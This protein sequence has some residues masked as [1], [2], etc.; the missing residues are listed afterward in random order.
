M[1]RMGEELDRRLDANKYL[2]YEA[3]ESIVKEGTRCCELVQQDRPV[4]EIYNIDMVDRIAR[5]ALARVEE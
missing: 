4:R 2:M 5:Q 3:L 1:S